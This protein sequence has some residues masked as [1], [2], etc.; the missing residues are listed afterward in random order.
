MQIASFNHFQVQNWIRNGKKQ[1]MCT[2]RPGWLTV[3][4]RFPKYKK[5]MQQIEVNLIDVLE[6]NEKK[7]VK[8]TQKN[9]IYFDTFL[10]Q[11][12]F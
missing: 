10:S 11:K 7:Q 4:F 9:L 5:T 3:C 8:M 12:P 6:I 1:L 2:A